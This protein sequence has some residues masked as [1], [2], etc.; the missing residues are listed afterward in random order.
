MRVSTSQ[1]YNIADVGMRNAQS[2]VNKTSEQISTGKRVLSPADDPVA[3]TSILRLNQELGRLEQYDKN[4]NAAENAL[5]QEEVALDSIVNLVQRMK[6]LGV[7]A[8][9]TGV[10]TPEDYQSIAAEVDTRIEELMNLQNTRNSSGQY[11]FAGHQGDKAPFSADGGGNFSYH[12]DEG[13]MRIQV[14]N[15]VNVPVGDSGKRLFVDIPSGHN[16]FNT[17]ASSANQANPPAE[18]SVGEIV[19]Q[20]AYDE[21]Y[22]GDMKITFN[23]PETLTP[24]R[25]NYTITDDKGRVLVANEPHDQSDPIEINGVR[26]QVTGQPYAGEAA[27][28][29]TLDFGAVGAVDFSTS[30]ETVTLTVGTRSETL[31][32]DRPVNNAADLAAAL[33]STTETVGGSGADRNADK[34]ANLGITADGTG[35]SV[36]NGQNL[37]V[38]NGTANTDTAFGFATQNEGSTST[39]GELAEPGDSFHIESSNKQGLLTTLSRLSEAM[40]NVEANPESKAELGDVVAKTLT[41]LDNALTNVISVQ[42][43]VGARLNTLE[44]SRDLNADTKLYSEEVL[45]DIENLD[46]AEASTRLQMQSMVLSAAQQSFVKVSGLSLFNYL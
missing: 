11:I 14:S 9:N 45:S 43:E 29:A 1:I 5:E 42:G 20:E 16:T 26:F 24:P 31:L 17:R 40:R 8:G 27:T 15:S 33:N 30:P 36:T 13:Q 23:A 37:T 6:E 10:L 18:I 19:D 39:D 46:Y 4:I 38:R 21:F 3:A 34:L 28:P 2:A 35:L 32:L 7:R 44:T 41:N 12:G 22:P 25:A